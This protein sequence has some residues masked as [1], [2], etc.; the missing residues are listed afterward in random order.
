MMFHPSVTMWT[1][2]LSAKILISQL[3]GIFCRISLTIRLSSPPPI[4]SLR[5]FNLGTCG[6]GNGLSLDSDID[7]LHWLEL[8]YRQN[9][10]PNKHIKQPVQQYKLY[11][12]IKIHFLNE[13][14]GSNQPKPTNWNLPQPAPFLLAEFSRMK[15]S[16]DPITHGQIL[17]D[18]RNF[19]AYLVASTPLHSQWPNFDQNSSSAG[20]REKSHLDRLKCF[21]TKLSHGHNID[22]STPPKKN[23]KPKIT[24]GFSLDFW[25]F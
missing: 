24:A 9:A 12:F 7:S 23:M 1:K 20:F 21:T 2:L 13:T 14:L 19:Q 16:I 5:N 22:T 18:I 17:P 6:C 25:G 10:P 15:S 8:Q 11:E 3:G 4:T